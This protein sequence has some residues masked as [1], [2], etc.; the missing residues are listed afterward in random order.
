MSPR[1]R[2]SGFTLLE[3]LLALTILSIALL[4]TTALLVAEPRIAG[5][6]D[7]DRQAMR[8]IESTL[9]AVRAGV[10]PLADAQLLGFSTQAGGAASRDLAVYLTVSPG[11]VAGLYRVSVSARYTVFGHAH[12][13][14]VETLV[15][16]TLP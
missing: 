6:F 1:R 7:A 14:H 4:F 13:K 9:E 5:R 10:I 12:E 2:Q 8:A 11:D 16:R 3:T 15:W